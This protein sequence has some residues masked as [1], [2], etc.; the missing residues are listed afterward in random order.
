MNT[1][2]LIIC[3][4]LPAESKPLLKPLKLSRIMRPGPV[5]YQNNHKN[6]TLVESGVGANAMATAVGIA[7]AHTQHQAHTFFLNI[8]IAGCDSPMGELYCAD[9]VI[10]ANT[11][12]AYYPH[13]HRGNKVSPK[14]LISYSRPQHNYSIE[15]MMDMEGSSFFSSANLCVSVEQIHLLK[16]ISDNPQQPLTLKA[17]AISELIDMQL[18]S[19]SKHIELLQKHSAAE[20]QYYQPIKDLESITNQWHFTHYQQHQ[21]K[22]YVKTWHSAYPQQNLL[23]HLKGCNNAKKVLDKLQSDNHRVYHQRASTCK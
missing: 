19:I 11:G 21:L 2:N 18:P 22:Q 6:I 3:A 12:S 13:L 15:H 4:A 16:V 8:G 20:C 10:D 17:K 1:S 23:E 9:K 5:L 7:F 14:T